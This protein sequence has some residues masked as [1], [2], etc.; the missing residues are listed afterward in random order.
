MLE[1]LRIREQRKIK[2]EKL[3]QDQI[4]NGSFDMDDK[5]NYKACQ[6]SAKDCGIST[7]R[8]RKALARIIDKIKEEERRLKQV[9]SNANK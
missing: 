7:G 3:V 1:L 4:L 6:S 2:E 9:K 8:F 5:Y